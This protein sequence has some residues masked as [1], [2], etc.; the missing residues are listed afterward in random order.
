[1]KNSKCD[2]SLWVNCSSRKEPPSKQLD[3]S[4][5]AL[6]TIT[7][8]HI[9]GMDAVHINNNKFSDN[10]SRQ[11]RHSKFMAQLEVETKLCESHFAEK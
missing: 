6:G 5:N 11:T 10:G 7:K 2:G 3:V 9:D 8:G 1:M 4:F